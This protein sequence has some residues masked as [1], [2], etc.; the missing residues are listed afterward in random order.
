MKKKT[1]IGLAT[2]SVLS[3]VGLTQFSSS[4]DAAT[5]EDVKAEL[6]KIEEK[7][8]IPEVVNPDVWSKL[9]RVKSNYIREKITEI[10]KRELLESLENLE[11]SPEE[12]LEELKLYSAENNSDTVT[13]VE[14]NKLS[15]EDLLKLKNAIEYAEVSRAETA[16][17][18]SLKKDKIMHDSFANHMLE[19]ETYNRNIANSTKKL[20]INKEKLE[21]LKEHL[22]RPIAVYGSDELNQLE[23]ELHSLT[24]KNVEISNEIVS[25]FDKLFYSKE[26]LI[27]V[28]NYIG[29]KYPEFKKVFNAYSMIKDETE[30]KKISGISKDKRIHSLIIEA[31]ELKEIIK[32]T[33]ERTVGI[34]DKLNEVLAEISQLTNTKFGINSVEPSIHRIREYFGEVNGAEAAVNEVPKFDLS[35]LQPEE[36]TA[37]P[38]QEKPNTTP[39]ISEVKPELKPEVPAIVEKEETSKKEETVNSWKQENGKW[40]RYDKDG[41]KQTGWVQDG[42]WYYLNSKGEMQTG[43]LLKDNTWYYLNN[44]GAM[45]K[46]WNKVDGKWYFMNQSGAMEKGWVEVSGKW[47]FMNLSGAMQTGWVQVSG[48]WYYFNQSGELLTNT[49]TPDGYYVN[50]NGEWI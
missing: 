40:Y 27:N 12:V 38:S 20:R 29:E 21:L 44:S 11:I 10:G 37:E 48:K 36:K 33:T 9:G 39:T 30:A 31:N 14:N 34:R 6:R 49:K 13:N 42:S 45:E 18:D 15:D 47:Y 32:V 3:T 35:T 2:L 50:A 17:Y 7:Y 43:W 24:E 1:L 4:V 25:N 22:N 23:E 19:I 26:N 8:E 5:I 41:K 28:V 46:G 16:V